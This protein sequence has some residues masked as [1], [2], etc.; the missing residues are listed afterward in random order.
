VLANFDVN[1]IIARDRDSEGNIRELDRQIL[2]FTTDEIYKWLMG[3]PPT[4]AAIEEELQKSDDGIGRDREEM[5]SLMRTSPDTDEE[6]ARKRV[7][8]FKEILKSLNR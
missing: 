2:V 7:T 5:A 3:T 4:G 6:A 8:E 1:E